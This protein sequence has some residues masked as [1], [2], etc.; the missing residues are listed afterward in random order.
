LKNNRGSNWTV[1]VKG[2]GNGEIK[3]KLMER[4]F[5]SLLDISGKPISGQTYFTM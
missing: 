5:G 2:Q 3:V 1:H 4:M